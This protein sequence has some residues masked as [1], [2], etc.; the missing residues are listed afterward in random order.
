MGRRQNRRPGSPNDPTRSYERPPLVSPR[1]QK[2]LQ[3]QY[4]D[5]VD[6]P[7]PLVPPDIV[8]VVQISVRSRGCQ[9]LIAESVIPFLSV[10]VAP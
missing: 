6:D 2:R 4:R 10:T 5:R 3:N 7:L 9:P 1:L 8:C